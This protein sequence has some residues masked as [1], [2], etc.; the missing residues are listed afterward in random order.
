LKLLL[1][2]LPS[3]E[4]KGIE[5][6]ERL[7]RLD[8]KEMAGRT[9][10]EMLSLAETASRQQVALFTLTNSQGMRVRITNYGGIVLSIEVPDR[11]GRLADVV[12]G[13][14]SPGEYAHNHPYF[15]AIIGRYANRIA[16]GRFTLGAEEYRLATNDGSN[17]LHGGRVGFDKAVWRVAPLEEPGVIGVTLTHVSTDGNEG[18]PGELTVTVTYCLTE[19]SEL[20][21][22]YRAT[23]DRPTIVNLTHHSYFNLA[24]HDSG[25]ILGH[26][27]QIA[28]DHFTPI[29]NNLIPTGE[30]RAVDGT[31]MD[32]KRLK[33]IGHEIGADDEQLRFGHGYD[34]NFVVN[35]IAGILRPAAYVFEPGSGRVME[36]LTTEPGLQFYS[37]NL[38]DS[39]IRG[40][41]D[42]EYGPRA[43]FCLEAQHFPNSPNQPDFPSVV[44]RPD[45]EYRQETVYRF[46]TRP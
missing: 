46:T 3:S 15:G 7:A 38:L 22:D 34:H 5:F 14:D 41:G 12:L 39:S 27:L 18:Y 13:F 30:R 9:T 40:K 44:L 37:G 19:A 20:R 21:I 17:H 42:A 23:A 6:G 43:G 31:A 1:A 2:L 16:D 35:G 11:R 10:V 45:G 25:D 8:I 36:V 32:F 29:D 4:S 24:G 33:P 28:A 26:R